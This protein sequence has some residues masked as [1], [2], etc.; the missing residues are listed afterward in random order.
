[1]TFPVF[2]AGVHIITDSGAARH[3]AAPGQTCV[4]ASHQP[5]N[6]HLNTTVIKSFW[7]VLQSNWRRIVRMP[8][9]RQPQ[10]HLQCGKAAVA[11]LP[12]RSSRGL[13]WSRIAQHSRGRRSANLPQGPPAPS[14]LPKAGWPQALL[15]H[16]SEQRFLLSARTSHTSATTRP[17]V[18]SPPTPVSC[19]SR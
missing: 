1:M 13:R 18:P 3:S 8:S 11:Q 2:R 19:N 4:A 15:R 5:H 10:G 17:T 7:T 12:Q 9:A 14:A 16:H 6:C